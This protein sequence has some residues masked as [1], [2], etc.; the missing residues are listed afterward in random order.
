MSEFMGLIKGNYEAKDGSFQPGGAS[1]HTMMTAHGPDF[2]CFEKAS[3]A[4]LKP[5][6]IAEGTMAF[7][8]ESSLCMGLTRWAATSCKLDSDYYKCWEGLKKHFHQ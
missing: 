3:H 8:F 4:Q 6:K 5:E 7:M 1:L 2:P